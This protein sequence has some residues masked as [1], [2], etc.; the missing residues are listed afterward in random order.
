MFF[1]NT[2]YNYQQFVFTTP[3]EQKAREDFSTYQ[4]YPSRLHLSPLLFLFAMH[5]LLN[6]ITFE[7]QIGHLKGISMPHLNLHYVQASYANNTHLILSAKLGNSQATK[8]ILQHFNIASSLTIQWTKSEVRWVAD[9]PRPLTTNVLQWAWKDLDS[10]SQLL[11]FSFI[12]SLRD[13]NMFHALLLKLKDRL[14]RWNQF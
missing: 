8:D 11:G 4:S 10:P 5:V 3:C 1:S 7:Q 2:C 14:Q 12:D 13:N 9:Y 6:C